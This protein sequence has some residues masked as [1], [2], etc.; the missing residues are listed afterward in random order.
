MLL[1]IF[2][3]VVHGQ[4]HG[5]NFLKNG[6]FFNKSVIIFR[7]KKTPETAVYKHLSAC[8]RDSLKNGP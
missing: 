3:D 8:F 4:I 7:H 1:I 2:F 6:L 5:Q